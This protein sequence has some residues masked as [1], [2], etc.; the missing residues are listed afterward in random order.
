MLISSDTSLEYLVA[1]NLASL[2]IRQSMV[3]SIW[4]W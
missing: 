3:W 2:G 1:Q 4:N